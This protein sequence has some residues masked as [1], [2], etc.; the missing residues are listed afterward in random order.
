MAYPDDG[1]GTAGVVL[2]RKQALIDRSAIGPDTPLRLHVAA[3]IAYP[4]GSMTTSGLR[5]EIQRGRLECEL[6]AGKQYVTLAGIERMREKCRDVRKVPASTTENAEAVS[7]SGSS[8]TDKMKLA[9]AAA[10]AI[11]SELKG[12]LPTTS[13][14][15]TCQTGKILTLQK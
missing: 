6:T 3:G 14:E 1:I 15:S 11:A 4:D 12:L 7:P 5:R 13:V 8:S 10:Q 9:L 2:M